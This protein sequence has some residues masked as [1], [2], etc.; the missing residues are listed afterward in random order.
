MQRY[1]DHPNCENSSGVLRN[2]KTNAHLKEIADVC[3][4]K[5]P[6]TFHIARHTFAIT[7]TPL[8]GVSIESLS[9]MLGLT[10]IKTT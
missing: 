6:I 2:Q 4:I 5:K 9:K 3:G 10:D 8:N 7:V 1:D